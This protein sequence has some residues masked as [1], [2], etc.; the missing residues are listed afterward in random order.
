MC[1][2]NMYS[3]ELLCTPGST[4]NGNFHEINSE[5][6]VYRTILLR[7]DTITSST[8]SYTHEDN[9]IK[10]YATYYD[11]SNISGIRSVRQVDLCTSVQLYN[12]YKVTYIYR[13]V[14]NKSFPLIC[15][16][17]VLDRHNPCMA[18]AYVYTAIAILY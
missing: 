2:Y 12:T 11:N 5:P 10:R 8:K 14:L 4:Y 6:Y 16:M 3:S 1:T 18:H 15:S 9:N 17:H 7:Y 13:T